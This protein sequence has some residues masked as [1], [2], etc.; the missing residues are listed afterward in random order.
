ME[1]L[2]AFFPDHRWIRTIQ[3]Q[4]KRKRRPF[5]GG[6]LDGNLPLHLGCKFGTDR[7]AQPC[8]P[9]LP[10]VCAIYLIEGFEDSIDFLRFYPDSGVLDVEAE[11]RYALYSSAI[12]ADANDGSSGFREFAGVVE[13]VQEDLS[14][15]TRITVKRVVPNSLRTLTPV[16]FESEVSSLKFREYR[17]TAF[18][19]DRVQGETG[20]LNSQRSRLRLGEVQN[21]SCPVRIKS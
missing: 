2:D 4:L 3:R 21:I 12:A 5:S 15:S 17:F 13:Q 16:N 8:A 18:L 6:A 9:L 19:Y 10:R 20:R 1:K 7:E 11:A 14:D